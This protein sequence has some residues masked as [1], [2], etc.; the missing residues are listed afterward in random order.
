VNVPAAAETTVPVSVK[1]GQS[2]LGQLGGRP[3]R[4]AMVAADR[5]SGALESSRAYSVKVLSVPPFRERF[6]MLGI[7]ALHPAMPAL[8]FAITVLADAVAF[9][10]LLAGAPLKHA[11]APLEKIGLF[12]SEPVNH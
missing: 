10:L 5:L 7:C 4:T 12:R 3:T 6:W 2:E 1:S 9:F 11:A 8:H